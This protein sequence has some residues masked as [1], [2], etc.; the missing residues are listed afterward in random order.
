MSTNATRTAEVVLAVQQALLGEVTPNLRAVIVARHD[1][2]SVFVV[3]YFDAEPSELEREAMSRVETELLAR[4]P[5]DHVVQVDVVQ[6]GE[7]E[8]I[9]KEGIWTYR[10]WEASQ[11]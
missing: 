7:P 6:L 3:A 4:F 9:P 10:R 5:E 11:S 2:S 1:A 8:L